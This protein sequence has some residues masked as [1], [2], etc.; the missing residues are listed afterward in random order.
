MKLKINIKY[1]RDFEYEI[2]DKKMAAAIAD[3]EYK[4]KINL[5]R[6]QESTLKL[7]RISY[8]LGIINFILNAETPELQEAIK[9]EYEEDLKEY[10]KD[11][12]EELYQ[13][14]TRESQEL[15]NFDYGSKGTYGD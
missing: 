7:D 13:S 10:F 12:A 1:V 3:I 4:R 8:R 5:L 2:T 9:E 14:W 15:E 6:E 11:D